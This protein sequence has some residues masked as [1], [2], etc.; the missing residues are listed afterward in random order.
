MDQLLF[1]KVT[2]IRIQKG[3][4]GR[5]R[6]AGIPLFKTNICVSSGGPHLCEMYVFYGYFVA[7]FILIVMN[8][9][10]LYHFGHRFCLNSCIISL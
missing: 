1:A 7:R 9:L 5:V 3:I 8:V 2:I 10:E 4:S 6:I